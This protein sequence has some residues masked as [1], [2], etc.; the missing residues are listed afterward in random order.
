MQ[1]IRSHMYVK[2]ITTPVFCV[3]KWCVS[4]VRYSHNHFVHSVSPW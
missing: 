2:I 3:R 1:A 4:A